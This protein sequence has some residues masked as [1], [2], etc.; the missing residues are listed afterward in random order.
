MSWSAF[1]FD[2]V[3]SLGLH[4]TENDVIVTGRTIEEAHVIREYVEKNIPRYPEK[5]PVYL[6]PMHLAIRGTGTVHSRTSSALHK[7]K[8]IVQ[9]TLK[10]GVPRCIFED[11]ALQIEV[12]ISEFKKYGHPELVDR[13]VHIRR[14]GDQGIEY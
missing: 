2:G 10:K 3:T 5:I 8:T 13:I 7:A 14:L 11:D 1:D 12:M 6:N 9:L 4:P